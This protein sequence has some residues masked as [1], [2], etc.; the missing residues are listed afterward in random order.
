MPKSDPN[1]ACAFIYAEELSSFE[2]SP[3]HPFKP[4]RAKILLDLCHRYG[5]LERPWIRIIKPLPSSPAELSKFHDPHYLD[6]LQRA[7]TLDGS[8][9]GEG[10]DE[11]ASQFLQ[12]GL[13]TEDNPIFPGIFDFAALCAGATQLGAKLLSTG[14]ANVV[15]NPLG[16]FHHA[17]SNRAEGFCYINDIAVAITNLLEEGRRVAFVDI[18]AHHGNGVQEAFYRDHRVL[19]ISFH[20]SGRYL[21]PWTGFEDEIGEGK[22]R[23]YN[24]NFP[25]PQ[26]CD[27]DTFL[28]GFQE[29]VPPLLESY[30]A[31]LLIAQI[32]AD[33]HVA[34]PLTHL[35][36]TN[37]GYSQAVK[38]LAQRSS[39]ILALGG[40]GYDLYKTAR[41][42]T[43]AW[44][45]LSHQEPK[46]DYVGAVGGMMYGPEIEAGEL[47]DRPIYARG[48]EKERML[49][50]V[51]RIVVYLK[52]VIFP[53]HRL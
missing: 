26:G 44:A 9:M 38:I 23:G 7:N 40:G 48:E 8:I 34:D 39:S 20:E 42:W 36:I 17:R 43:L 45:I 33:M 19:K 21:Y 11:L 50:E 46:D 13:G 28:R 41:N 1:F 31:D 6:V 51:D 10:L 16:G 29:I 18:D 12:Y 4:R 24:V 27:D 22:G 2:F 49:K 52:K 30:N 53:I 35:Q 25:L 15:F 14:E 32:G 37:A 47:S 5:L 3:N